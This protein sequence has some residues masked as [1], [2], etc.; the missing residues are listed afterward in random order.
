MLYKGKY[1][2]RPHKCRSIHDVIG[3][4]KKQQKLTAN[5]FLTI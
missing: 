3:F 2:K 5:D 4:M 1:G